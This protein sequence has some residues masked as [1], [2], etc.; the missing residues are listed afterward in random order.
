MLVCKMKVKAFIIH[1]SSM[2]IRK[3]RMETLI[4]TFKKKN[5]AEFSVT[6]E[7]ASE[8]DPQ[9]LKQEDVIN[10]VNLSKLNNGELFDS[11][12]RNLHVNQISNALKHSSV[13]AKIAEDTSGADAFLV[14][15]DDA[16]N[17]DDVVEK[18]KEVVTEVTGPRAASYDLV[19][20]G[21]PSLVPLES[22]KMQFKAT[23]DFYKIFPCCDSYIGTKAAFAKLAASWY[24]IKYT[25]NIQLSYIS[26]TYK[27]NTHMVVPNVFLD[28]SKYGAYLSSVDANS[29]LVF[30]PDFNKLAMLV[31]QYASTFTTAT[32][33]ANDAIKK[34][35]DTAFDLIKFKNHPDV[36]H[37][38]AVHLIN[39]GDY[40]KAE[41][42]LENIYTI[43]SQNGCVINSETEFLRTY[44]KLSKF[45]QTV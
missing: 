32:T 1:S 4:D 9:T 7:Y 17:G 34:E 18:L 31:N 36:M 42:I 13:I 43:V 35:I 28:G 3:Q 20:L 6:F 25:T 5:S 24:P 38:S 39:Q 26:Q 45:T 11:L 19:F 21:L 33:T 30:N 15:E 14:L 2:D 8:F 16:L 29:K 40:A 37:L 10:K 41:T 22:N 44:I 27:V 23:S 12:I